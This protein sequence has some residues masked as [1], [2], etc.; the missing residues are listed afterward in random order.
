M[1]GTPHGTQFLSE[2]G[3]GLR[4]S[5]SL[6][7]ALRGTLSDPGYCV[8]PGRVW[9]MTSQS[10]AGSLEA[11]VSLWHGP[12]R[13]SQDSLIG[14]GALLDPSRLST[15]CPEWAPHAVPSTPGNPRRC[16]L[17]CKRASPTGTWCHQ[18][19]TGLQSTHSHLK[20]K[21]TSAHGSPTNTKTES[22][23]RPRRAALVPR[24]ACAGEARARPARRQRRGPLLT[25]TQGQE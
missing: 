15:L 7:Q 2:E 25:R 21:Q 10:Q 8:Q 12:E 3:V 20:A 22:R 24:S 6:H 23:I 18:D 17:G 5:P 13:I 9:G 16:L 14:E 19:P 1:E 4:V 11:E